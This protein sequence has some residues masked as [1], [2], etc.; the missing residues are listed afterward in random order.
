M[1]QGHPRLYGLMVEFAT[2]EDLLAG[3]RRTRDAGYRKIDAFT[4]SPIHGLTEAIGYRGRGWI[5]RT[6]FLGGLLGATGGFALQWWVST[7][8]Y[9]LNVGGRPTFSWPA[10][11]PV[12]FELTILLAV[13]AAVL[14]MLGWNKLPQPYHPVFNVPRFKLATS[15]RFFLCVESID[16]LFDADA[17]RA[18]LEG[19]DNA[20]GVYDVEY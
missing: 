4:P 8:A 6:V 16:P 2:T 20:V 9:P 11:V 14:G 5:A 10:F 13:I 15:D 12:T 17:T 18:F 7:R 1:A 19:L 3:C